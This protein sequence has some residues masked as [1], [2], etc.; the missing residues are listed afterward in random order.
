MKKKLFS[1]LLCA[2]LIFANVIGSNVY[3]FDLKADSGLQS[4][5]S[6]PNADTK[7]AE[8]IYKEI[9]DT[10]SF[11]VYIE[12]NWNNLSVEKDMDLYNSTDKWVGKPGDILITVF[13]KN[14][15]DI[16]AIT[17]GSLTTHAAFVDSDPTK[18]LELF[19]DGI[20][21]RE[22][23]WRTRYK[24]ILI[25]RPKVDPKIISDA[26][27]YGYTKIGTPFSYFTNMFQKT[28]ID[29]YYC[30]QFVWDCYLKSGV[31]LDGNGGKAVFPYDFL[32][33]DK[34]SIVYKQG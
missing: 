1:S 18:V 25:V 19:Q 22:N 15:S 34:V 30:S 5:I 32:R 6:R 7:D 12:K 11:Q 3:A 2:A 16:N 33:S 23:D 4:Y 24:K 27:A 17:M 13:D 28:K 9:I 31:D 29:K 14:N 8:A 26:I 20:A 21:K 10:L